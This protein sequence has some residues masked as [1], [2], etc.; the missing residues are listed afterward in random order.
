MIKQMKNTLFI[1]AIILTTNTM[2]AQEVITKHSV[3]N[4][5]IPDYCQ[6]Q[7]AGNIGFISGGIGYNFLNNNLES[8]V[9]YGYVPKSIGDVEIHHLTLK[10]TFTIKKWKL[11]QSINIYATT[12]FSIS[13][14]L[15]GNTFLKLP[16]QYP[17]GYYGPNAV[18]GILFF[19]TKISGKNLQ[20]NFLNKI[21]LFYELVIMDNDLWYGIKSRYT[22]FTEQWSLAVG[23]NINLNK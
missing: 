13:F 1:A 9:L 20:P 15:F 5:L 12:G 17:D 23:I 10:N 7:F 22:S 18:H 3:I 11:S 14:N 8:G 16:Y 2:F 21:N 19:G 6:L 4:K